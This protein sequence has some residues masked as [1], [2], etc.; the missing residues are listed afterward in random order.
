MDERELNDFL[1]EAHG[2]APGCVLIAVL[3]VGITLVTGVL[4][5]CFRLG[6]VPF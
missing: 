3:V 6:V 4:Y 5:L 2:D 1:L